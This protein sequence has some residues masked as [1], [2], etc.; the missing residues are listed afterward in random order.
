MTANHDAWPTLGGLGTI[1]RINILAAAYPYAAYVE[2]VLDHPFET[3][4]DTIEN[5]E[6]SVPTFDATVHRLTI[7]DRNDTGTPTLATATPFL[8]PFPIAL[9]LDLR[10]GWC[11][12]HSTSYMVCFAAEPL[13][14]TTTRYAHLEGLTNTSH[15]ATRLLQRAIAPLLRRHVRNDVQ[16]IQHLFNPKITLK[17]KDIEP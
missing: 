11:L 14:A 2:T 15:T 1:A 5:L 13:T 10:P 9:T 12:M 17:S 6:T 4:W 7:T 16:G 3:V 8:I